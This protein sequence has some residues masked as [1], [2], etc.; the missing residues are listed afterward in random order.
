MKKITK[1]W[2]T[3]ALDDLMVIEKIVDEA[4]LTHIVAFHAQQAIEKSIKAV[5][6]ERDIDVPKIHNLLTLFSKIEGYTS[7]S[8]DLD[9]LKTLDALYVDARY[10]GDFGLLPNG[11]PGLEEAKEFFHIARELHEAIKT[12]LN[13]KA[14]QNVSNEPSDQTI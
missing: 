1:E 11:K 2:L 12:E 5:M 9:F 8:A 13:E 7:Y 14:N 4:H 10:P 6:E 3:A